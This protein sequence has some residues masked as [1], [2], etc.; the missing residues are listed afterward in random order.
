M[1]PH[2]EGTKQATRHTDKTVEREGGIGEGKQPLGRVSIVR[3][4]LTKAKLL[5][6]PMVQEHMESWH[7]C[8]PK[9]YW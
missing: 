1:S 3:K 2:T 9:F 8:I 7:M 6:C 5:Q 4:M